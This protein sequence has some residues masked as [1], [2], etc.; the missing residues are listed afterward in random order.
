MPDD[1]RWSALVIAGADVHAVLDDLAALFAD[2]HS[3]AER[4]DAA[5]LASGLEARTE[6]WSS[7]TAGLEQFAGRFVTSES[8]AAVDAL[9]KPYL[10]RRPPLFAQRDRQRQPLNS[11]H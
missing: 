5:N 11:S 8:V 7:N 4:G 6:R 9:A 10:A 1:R 2:F 3:H